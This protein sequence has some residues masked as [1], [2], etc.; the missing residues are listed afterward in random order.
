MNRGIFNYQTFH[1]R[2]KAFKVSGLA[3]VLLGVFTIVDMAWNVPIPLTGFRA[4][5]AGLVLIIFGTLCLYHGYKLPLE[6]AI[7]IIH[8]RGKGITASELVHEMRVDRVTANRIIDALLRK[9]FLRS[10]AQRSDAEEVFDP[11]Q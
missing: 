9:G 7:E 5:A 4:L 10:S 6:E 3:L 1:R 8:T 2:R 11:V